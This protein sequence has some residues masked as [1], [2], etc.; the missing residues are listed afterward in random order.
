MVTSWER[1]LSALAREM[2]DAYPEDRQP[3]FVAAADIAWA[4]L[5]AEKLQAAQHV[6]DVIDELS[7]VCPDDDTRLVADPRTR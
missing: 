4:L 7:C 6:L 3:R 5:Y 1:R 2:E